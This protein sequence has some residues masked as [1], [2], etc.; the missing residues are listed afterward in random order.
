MVDLAAGMDYSYRDVIL[1]KKECRYSWQKIFMKCI[2][3]EMELIRPLDQEEEKRVLA[4]AARADKEAGNRLVEGNL[5][6]ALAVA[7]EYE[8]KELPFPIL[9]RRPIWLL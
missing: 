4:A 7:K 6:R 8:G 3:R 1:M 9:S 5:A 2:W